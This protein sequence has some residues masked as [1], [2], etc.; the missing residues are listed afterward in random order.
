MT[1]LGLGLKT[2]PPALYH[3]LVGLARELGKMNECFSDYHGFIGMATSLELNG[4]ES[5]RGAELR[6]LAD[7]PFLGLDV[8]SGEATLIFLILKNRDAGSEA[9]MLAY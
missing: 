4:P 6:V 3:C 9:H 8:I 2:K 5:I 7:G 1:E